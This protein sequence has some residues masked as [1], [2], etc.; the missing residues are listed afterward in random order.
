MPNEFWRVT[1]RYWEP[2][3]E[4]LSG[5]PSKHMRADS[6]VVEATSP[7]HAERIARTQLGR[8]LLD[9]NLD[10]GREIEGVN[11]EPIPNSTPDENS[12]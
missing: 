3:R 7:Q 10:W 11:V 12:G 5:R 2:N 6:I 8:R 1:I 4:I 9:S